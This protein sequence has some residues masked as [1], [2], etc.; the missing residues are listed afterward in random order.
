[1]VGPGPGSP[2][3]P[4]D[5][6]IVGAI[7]DMPDDCLLPVFGVCLGLQSLVLAYGGLLKRLDVVKHGLISEVHHTGKDIFE[8]VGTAHVVR[9]HSLHVELPEDG[10]IEAL[11]YA[12]DGTENGRVLMAAHHRTKPFWGVQYHPESVR[13]HGGGFEVL[14]NFWRRAQCWNESRK[15]QP[16]AWTGAAEGLFGLNWPCLRP[17]C[18]PALPLAHPPLVS[19]AILDKCALS[20]AGICEV[21]GV[22]DESLPFVLLDSAAAPGRFSII[23]ALNPS[24][25]RIMYSV[26]DDHVSVKRDGLWRHEPLGAGNVWSWIASFMTCRRF[27][28]GHPEIP[29]WGGLIGCLSYEL[30]VNGHSIPLPHRAQDTKNRRHPDINLVFVE[31]SIVVDVKMGTIYVQSLLPEDSWVSNTVATLSQ[32]QPSPYLPAM[33]ANLLPPVVTLPDKDLYISRIRIAQA[34]LAAGESY[35][36]CLTAPTRI[37]TPC[38]PAWSL[39]KSARAKNPAPY[40]AFLRLSPTTLIS[41]SPERFLSYSRGPRPRCE[42]RPIKGTLRKAAGVGR[43]EAEH[44]LAGSAKEVAENLMIVDLIRHDLH[45]VLGDDVHV[46]QFCGIEEYETVWQMVSVIEGRLPEGCSHEEERD[47]G[48][49]V[50]GR[51]LPPGEHAVP[52]P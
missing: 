14:Q 8:G 9:Y 43:P 37:R 41:S 16:L 27:N 34:H 32:A 10:P 3:N 36:L 22:A 52:H 51:S 42:L 26:G 6:G 11:A 18:P 47:I 31:R 7:W 33:P 24:S 50:L 19:T 4:A 44:A 25:I 40:A 13:S 29:F 17:Q 38:L 23:G 1:M 35:E 45:G 48:W 30:G 21:L 20:V 49:E 28:N 39:Y 15:R 5:V 46:T 2:A 12:D